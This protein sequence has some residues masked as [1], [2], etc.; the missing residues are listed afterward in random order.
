M[1]HNT[2]P[3]LVYE[4]L[5][6]VCVCVCVCFGNSNFAKKWLNH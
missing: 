4:P 6:Y 1:G 3:L 5:V 2:Y